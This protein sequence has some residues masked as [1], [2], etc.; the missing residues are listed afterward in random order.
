MRPKFC[1]QARV[2]SL[3]HP[4]LVSFAWA[5]ADVQND[6]WCLPVLQDERLEERLEER[7]AAMRLEMNVEIRREMRV[8]SPKAAY[9]NLNRRRSP[10][11]DEE[12][13]EELANEAQG[14]VSRCLDAD[15]EGLA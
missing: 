15:L 10:P 11:R 6:E 12:E 7:L 14:D 3:E 5:S 9:P 13:E 1:S 4:L 8:Q 2:F